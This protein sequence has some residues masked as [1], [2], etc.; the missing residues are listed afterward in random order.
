MKMKQ[1]L[2]AWILFFAVI[3]CSFGAEWKLED[4]SIAWHGEL[5][6]GTLRP[7]QLD[8]KINGKTLKLG[9]ECFKVQLGGGVVLKSS[10]FKLEGDPEIVALKPDP[11]S[12]VAARHFPGRQFVA[13]FSA[14]NRNLSAEWRVILR[15]GSTY[16]RQELALHATGKDVHVGRSTLFEQMIPGVIIDGTVQGSPAVAGN[17]FFGSEHPW[18]Y[19]T[20]DSNSVLHCS[21]VCHT[22]LKDGETMTQSCVLGVT[23]NGQ[24]RR[25]FLAYIERERA[26]PY[27]PFLHYNSWLDISWGYHQFGEPE[28]LDAINQFGV[29]LVKKRG[30]K[31]DSFL[32]DDGWD[33]YCTL[34]Q[35]N[36]GFPNGFTPLKAAAAQYGAFLGVW[37][38][39]TG[40]YEKAQKERLK[41]GATQ[42][43]E[44]NVHGFVMSGPKYYKQFR[45]ICFDMMTHYGV[46][47]FKFDGIGALGFDDLLKL[48]TEL[49]TVNPD[50]Y[51][52]ATSGSWPSPFWL[53]YADST[54][55]NGE[56]HGSFG[57][58]GTKCQR[59][60]TY[61]DQTTHENVVERGPL[62][63]LNSIML[64]GI[65]YAKKDPCGR[66][67]KMSDADFADQVHSFFGTGTQMQEMYITP[68]LLD[69]TN[70]DDIAEGATW[71]RANA[72]VLV[73]TH[74]VGGDPGKGELYGWASWSPRKGILTLR[75]PDDKPA[76]FTADVAKLFELPAGSA[77]AYTMHSPWKKDQSQSSVELRAGEP[78]TFNLQPFE[79]LVLESK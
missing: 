71:S 17:F 9:G 11:T 51:I 27:R 23:P 3:T 34:W 15:D 65:I 46:N 21:L 4:K 5:D 28:C 49:R 18:P 77:T 2:L 48:D 60:I 20:V 32:F 14:P 62:Y 26:H 56:D 45:A 63:P 78:R 76:S 24:R 50:A 53:L 57:T 1:S 75:N 44:T 73:D 41:Y 59:W 8:D 52:S 13:K 22:V 54:W 30:V 43:F 58:K 36:S 72:D 33:N 64:H 16:V 61:R 70:W 35:F 42:G 55:R 29:E 40:G 31:L 37:L 6:G 7:I 10:D 39:P 47:V 67:S 12:L 25:G 19:D 38:S 69:Q 79:V 68:A 66:L 74:W